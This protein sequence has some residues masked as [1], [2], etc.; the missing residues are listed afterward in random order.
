MSLGQSWTDPFSNH[1]YITNVDVAGQLTELVGVGTTPRNLLLPLMHEAAHHWCFLSPVGNAIALV[2]AQARHQALRILDRDED[3]SNALGLDFISSRL[4]TEM[5]RPIAEG[6]ALAME[7]DVVNR[8]SPFVS[9][10][11]MAV[12]R[13]F[14]P[15]AP[16]TDPELSAL[17]ANGALVKARQSQEGVA[18]RLNVYADRLDAQGTGYLLGYLSARSMMRKLWL[19]NG[20]LIE[21]A[22][23]CVSYLRTYVYG[24]WELVDLILER[25]EQDH[26][27]FANNI[28]S[29]I[30]DRL[31]DMS[32][33]SK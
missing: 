28:R 18:R 3:R 14:A 33:W 31:W 29:Y 9:W 32:W 12:S 27:H 16:G 4:A 30:S 25:E 11:L 17:A 1:T 24:D 22:D 2:N 5:L 8:K 23:L 7:F 19:A 10:P 15:A 13:A 6:I 21:E 20:R 26:I